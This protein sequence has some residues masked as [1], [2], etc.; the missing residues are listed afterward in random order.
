MTLYT[1]TPPADVA[2]LARRIWYWPVVRGVLALLFGLLAIFLPDKTPGLMVQV[3]GI[4][5][6]VDGL[7]SLVDGLR[8]RRSS[9]GSV[10]TG[11]G[12]VA[13]VLGALLLFLP[14]VF[15]GIALVL[16]AIWAL[17]LGLLQLFVVPALRRRGGASWVW[18][19]IAGVL[20][21]A[22]A[23]VCFVNPGSAIVG[24]SVLI[25]VFAVVIGV[26]MLALG[27]KLRA[28]GAQAAAGG[29][30]TRR[31]EIVEGEVVDEEE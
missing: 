10:N 14:E 18:N 11:V 13:L 2:A 22:L 26:A 5:V 25:G 7:V 29:P 17:L 6:L 15:L 21:I 9:A 16:V 4:F 28:L 8:R 27:L 20:L 3:F 1:F 12:V 23:V 31:G 30:P 24:L 19:L